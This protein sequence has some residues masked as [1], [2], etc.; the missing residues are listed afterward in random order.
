VEVLVSDGSYTEQ[1]RRHRVPRIIIAVLAA[2]AG[3]A[4]LFQYVL[5]LGVAASFSASLACAG[6]ILTGIAVAAAVRTP[7]VPPELAE[8]YAKLTAD[9]WRQ[10]R[11]RL[12]QRCDEDG[13]H[14]HMIAPGGQQ[15]V[16]RWHPVR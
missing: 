16:L 11:L 8:D 14:L 1:R 5:G 12:W 10:A 3:F 15:R 9:G 7:V 2:W 4:L 6:L 13:P